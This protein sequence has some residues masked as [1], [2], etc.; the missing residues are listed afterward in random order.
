MGIEVSFA[1]LMKGVFLTR[2]PCRF[3]SSAL[4][5]KWQLSEQM[6]SKHV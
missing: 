5:S 1:Y 2:P 4:A 3:G 6:P